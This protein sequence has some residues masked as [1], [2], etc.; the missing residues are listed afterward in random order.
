MTEKAVLSHLSLPQFPDIG[1]GGLTC[2]CGIPEGLFD[3]RFP[4]FCPAYRLARD[5]NP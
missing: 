3:R 1:Y 2:G 5:S 4:L